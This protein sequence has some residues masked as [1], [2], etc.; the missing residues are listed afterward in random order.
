MVMMQ[1]AAA[2]SNFDIVGSWDQP[3]LGT[4]L[5]PG[6]AAIFG[7]EEDSTERGRAGVVDYLGIPLNAGGSEQS[8]NNFLPNTG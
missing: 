5:G 1:P 8:V 3:A 2:Q 7:F 4:V 6:I